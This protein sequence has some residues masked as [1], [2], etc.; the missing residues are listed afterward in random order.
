MGSI[1]SIQNC[2]RHAQ[3]LLFFFYYDMNT[4]MYKVANLRYGF[5][6]RCEDS[7]NFYNYDFDSFSCSISSLGY[8]K[9]PF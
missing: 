2:V 9:R 6:F 8:P 3:L 4:F 1:L 5:Y 7:W